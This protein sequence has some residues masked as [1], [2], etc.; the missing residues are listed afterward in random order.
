MDDPEDYPR[1]LGQIFHILHDEEALDLIS[2]SSG[3]Q[4]LEEAFLNLLEEEKTYGFLRA[5]GRDA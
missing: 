1:A 2:F 5:I 3:S 4:S